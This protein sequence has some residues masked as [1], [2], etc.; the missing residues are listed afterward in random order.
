M[1]PEQLKALRQRNEMRAHNAI[2]KLGRKWVMHPSNRVTRKPV[3]LGAVGGV[4]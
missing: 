1:T 3:E 4:R 2:M